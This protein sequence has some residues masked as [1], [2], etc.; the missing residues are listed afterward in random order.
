[1]ESLRQWRRVGEAADASALG[2]KFIEC[3]VFGDL[4]VK[5]VALVQPSS[6]LQG[7]C[8]DIFSACLLDK[9]SSRPCAGV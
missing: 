5:C 8:C 2:T 3:L 6:A 4:R 9:L 1:M 7:I